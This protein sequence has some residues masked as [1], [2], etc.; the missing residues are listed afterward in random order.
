VWLL[1]K[2]FKKLLFIDHVVD[3]R[4]IEIVYN[5]RTLLHWYARGILFLRISNSRYY[6]MCSAHAFGN[7]CLVTIDI[8]NFVSIGSLLCQ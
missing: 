5:V 7:L 6:F 2:H 4:F 3:V 8:Q 1:C